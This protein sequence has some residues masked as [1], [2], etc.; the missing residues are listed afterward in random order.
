MLASLAITLGTSAF[1]VLETHRADSPTGVARVF[2]L[3]GDDGD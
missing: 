3:L 2:E 1:L